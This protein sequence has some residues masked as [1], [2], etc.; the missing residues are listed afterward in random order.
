MNSINSYSRYIKTGLVAGSMFLSTTGANHQ[1]TFHKYDPVVNIIKP[2][3]QKVLR[4]PSVIKK[5]IPIEPLS[6]SEKVAGL[7]S[8]W[9]CEKVDIQKWAEEFCIEP[10][11]YSPKLIK[12]ALFRQYYHDNVQSTVDQFQE[13]FGPEYTSLEY[14]LIISSL[15]ASI[16]KQSSNN[17]DTLYLPTDH[18]FSSLIEQYDVEELQNYC[19]KEGNDVSHAINKTAQSDTYDFEESYGVFRKNNQMC[20][21]YDQVNKYLQSVWVELWS[22]SKRKAEDGSSMDYYRTGTEMEVSSFRNLQKII[23]LFRTQYPDLPLF[24]SGLKEFGHSCDDQVSHSPKNFGKPKESM[25]AACHARS[26]IMGHAVDIKMMGAEG[27]IMYDRLR[28]NTINTVKGD[29]QIGK[30][31]TF[32]KGDI[33][34]KYMFHGDGAIGKHFHI[35][36]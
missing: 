17:N 7:H 2:E 6:L 34:F 27:L 8:M 25:S 5:A 14:H 10:E 12:A 22:T 15:L 26:H 30:M 32:K 36:L 29:I 24:V 28:E 21:G 19:K 31:H 23:A 1:P 18:F 4:I 33:Q 35:N 3:I 11:K 13:K 16:W 20:V 9:E